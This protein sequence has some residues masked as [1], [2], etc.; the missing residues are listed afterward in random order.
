MLSRLRDQ[1]LRRRTT[2]CLLQLRC[3]RLRLGR[4]FV[5]QYFNIDD[6]DP[7]STSGSGANQVICYP[8]DSAQF[9]NGLHSNPWPTNCQEPQIW[10]AAV[11]L[12]APGAKDR[13]IPRS[14]CRRR[15]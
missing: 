11:I 5:P 1:F 2:A 14:G 7:F 15:I 3:E 13:R 4:D 10:M 12:N 8:P 9:V 6:F